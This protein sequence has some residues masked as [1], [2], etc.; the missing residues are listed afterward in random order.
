MTNFED[1]LHRNLL[2]VFNERDESLRLPLLTALYAPDARFA[3]HDGVV[4][5][6]EVINEKIR[7]LHVRTPGFVFVPGRFHEVQDLATLEWSYGP[8]GTEPVVNGTDVAIIRDGRI[9]SL[10]VYLR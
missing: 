9:G 4:I 5:G 6:L 8:A 2:G 10:Y 1:M 3:D 7:E